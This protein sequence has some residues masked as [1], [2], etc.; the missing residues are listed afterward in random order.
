MLSFFSAIGKFYINVD[1]LDLPQL[2]FT[3][4]ILILVKP[5]GKILTKAKYMNEE[6]HFSLRYAL[7]KSRIIFLSTVK[8]IY[9]TNEQILL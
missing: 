5:Y 2:F 1:H 4:F 6:R 8:V 9:K 7:I 3:T